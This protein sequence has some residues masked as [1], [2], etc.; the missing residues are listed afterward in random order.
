MRGITA[1]T[2]PSA[3][4]HRISTRVWSSASAL[5]NPASMK[6]GPASATDSSSWRLFSP[7]AATG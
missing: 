4:R 3:V 7:R 1:R 5:I 2:V 6:A